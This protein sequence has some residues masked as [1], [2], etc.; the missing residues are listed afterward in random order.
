M[1]VFSIAL[2]FFEIF[3][4]VIGI[5]LLYWWTNKEAIE[6]SAAMP[7]YLTEQDVMNNMVKEADEAMKR[8]LIC[9]PAHLGGFL[10]RETTLELQS[11]VVY[12]ATRVG[13]AKQAQFRRDRR[14]FFADKNW[15]RY[16]SLI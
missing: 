15:R 2:V 5:L 12:H 6:S 9:R 13:I 16:R 3:T 4:V 7:N 10:K 1:D 11:I 8:N 14:A